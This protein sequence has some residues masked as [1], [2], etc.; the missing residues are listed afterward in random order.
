MLRVVQDDPVNQFPICALCWNCH[1]TVYLSQM[2]TGTEISLS[3][4][5]SDQTH[6]PFLPSA[7]LSTVVG[8]SLSTKCIS[9]CGNPCKLNLGC[10]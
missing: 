8:L 3:L 5:D 4:S 2:R 6:L 10:S 9:H 7:Y 1:F